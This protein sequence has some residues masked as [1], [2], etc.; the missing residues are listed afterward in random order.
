MRSYSK[1]D[2]LSATRL[3]SVCFW[4]PRSFGPRASGRHTPALSRHTQQPQSG[5]SVHFRRVGAV[6]MRPARSM[7]IWE[8]HCPPSRHHAASAGRKRF[9]IWLPVRARS[10]LCRSSP[11]CAVPKITAEPRR[12]ASAAP[13]DQS[14]SRFA[15]NARAFRSRFRRLPGCAAVG[16]L[17]CSMVVNDLNVVGVAVPEREANAPTCVHG[18]RPLGS[19]LSSRSP[20]LLRGLRSR[21]VAGTFNANNRSVAAAKS[22][23]DLASRRS[24]FCG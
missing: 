22:R 9:A 8:A 15:L 20:T 11:N 7:A 23:R 10:P 1:G 18:H 17:L 2:N 3:S 4:S 16:T 19:P 12:C 5:C 24:L 21:R 14:A 13:R 6:E